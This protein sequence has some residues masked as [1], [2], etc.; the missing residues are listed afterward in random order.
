MSFEWKKAVGMV[1]PLLGT[2]LGGPLGGVALSAVSQVLT[3]KTGSTETEIANAMQ[4]AQPEQLVALQTAEQEFKIKMRELGINE[5]ALSYKDKADAR[6]MAVKRP[7]RTP[8][9]LAYITTAMVAAMVAGLF[10]YEIPV[11]NEKT[12]YALVGTLTTVWI[13]A[14]QFYHGAVLKD[15]HR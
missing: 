11:G 7:D 15:E 1:A 2:A 6:L 10:F 5:Q 12:V 3:G 14:M 13:G 4:S 9:I 8:A